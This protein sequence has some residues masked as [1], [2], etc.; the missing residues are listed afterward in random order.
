MMMKKILILLSFLMVC[1]FLQAQE[2][3]KVKMSELLTLIRES[4]HPLIV[5][6]WATFCGPCVEEIPYFQ[7]AVKKYENSGTELL[8]VSLDLPGFFPDKIRTF[9]RKR[10]FN[11]SL[12]WL[13]ETDADYF[14]PMIDSAW[15]GVMPATLLI[16]NK[17]GYRRFFEEQIP[18]DTI[19]AEIRRLAVHH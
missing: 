16:D 8:L 10:N 14:C 4:N 19:E 18:R 5:N 6:F 1:I 12:Y 11:A 2:V 13:D 15:S 17:T 7:E 3:Q 9:A